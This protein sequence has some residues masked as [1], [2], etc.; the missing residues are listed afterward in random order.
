MIA[1]CLPSTLFTKLADKIVAG[2]K[3]RNISAE[4]GMKPR[5]RY[6]ADSANC[7]LFLIFFGFTG[8]ALLVL[9]PATLSIDRFVAH[10]FID[11][12][13]LFFHVYLFFLAI[14][15]L[16]LGALEAEYLAGTGKS[17]HQAIRRLLGGI[18]L[19][20]FITIPYIIFYRGVIRAP[21]PPLLAITIYVLLIGALFAVVSLYLERITSGT[22]LGYLSKYFLLFLYLF[23]FAFIL[24]Q[25]NPLIIISRL[26]ASREAVSLLEFIVVYAVPLGLIALVVWGILNYKAKGKR[27]GSVR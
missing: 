2:G 26:L 14:L 5:E 21:W 13:S 3:R 12:T 10:E 19:A 24:P 8:V 27:Y 6:I 4:E 15:G 1:I 22:I 16:N 9:T 17:A 20:C 18:A 25:I 11:G 7:N 23:G